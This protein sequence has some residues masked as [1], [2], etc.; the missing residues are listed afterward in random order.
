MAGGMLG[1]E[2]MPHLHVELEEESAL[3]G[4]VEDGERAGHDAAVG[5]ERDEVLAVAGLVAVVPRQPRWTRGRAL[6]GSTR[7]EQPRWV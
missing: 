7:V 5:R 3:R 6:W 4:A 1:V 2:H